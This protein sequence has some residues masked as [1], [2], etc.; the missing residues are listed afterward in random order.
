M[1]DSK[2]EAKLDAKLDLHFKEF[3][4]DVKGEIRGEVRSELHS[5]FEQY[6][7]PPSIVVHGVT[8][9]KGKGVL[10]TPSGFVLS[11]MVDLRQASSQSRVSSGESLGRAYQV[12]FPHFDGSDFRG[13]C[14]KLE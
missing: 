4:E 5:F 9:N 13:W 12:N 1:A 2:L 7:P 14:S 11:P 10:G 3:H 6:F 8:P